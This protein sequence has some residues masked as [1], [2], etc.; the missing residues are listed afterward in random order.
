M[1]NRTTFFTYVRNAPFG[2]RLKQSQVDGMNAI[3]DAWENSGMK[4][5]RWLAYM[6]ATVFWE[7]AQTMQPVRET[8]AKSDKQ[9]IANLEKA[10]NAGKLPSVKTPYWRDGSF[11]R[12]LVQLTHMMNYITMGKIIG[13]DLAGDPSLALRSDIAIEIMF[14]GM[15]RGVSSKGD[16]TGKSLEDY[17][18]EKTDDPVGAR[19]IING[20]DK[21]SLIAGFHKNFLDAIAAAQGTDKASG[22]VVA[23]DVPNGQS[24]S[25]WTIF[26]GIF[27][28]GGFSL[29]DA[30]SGG[31]TVLTAISNPWALAAFVALLCGGSALFWLVW[32]GRIQILRGEARK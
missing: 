7:T 24:K 12:G 23:D 32:S 3:L 15:T 9:A 6:L 17:F 5:T 11:G 27:G 20:N 2:G 18:N 29:M 1:L 10:W 4:D 31:S 25:L 16:F 19:K 30:M 22:P 8:L 21:A 14:E 28:G 13:V 26:A